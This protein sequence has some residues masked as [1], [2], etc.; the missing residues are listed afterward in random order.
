MRLGF[1]VAMHVQPDILLLGRGARRRRRGVPAEVLRQDLA[2]SSAA[3]GTIVFVSHD[4]AAVE[5]LCDRAIT[6]SSTDASSSAGRPSEVV[7]AYHR[8]LRGAPARRDDRRVD[9]QVDRFV[10][11]ARGAGGRGRPVDSRQLHG[12]RAVRAS[13]SGCASEDGPRQRRSVTIGFR[14]GGGRPLGSQTTRP[15]STFGR[16]E[17]Q[18]GCGSTSTSCRCAR[19][20]SSSTSGSSV[21]SDDRELAVAEQRARADASTARRRARRADSARRHVGAAA[22]ATEEQAEV[23]SR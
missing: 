1:S 17:L 7:R 11:D 23:V 22:P 16:N 6:V 4:P 15:P 21:T 12:G 14:D 20:A 18:S 9:R 5:Q 13:R 3:G 10:P 8:R 2:T 19:G